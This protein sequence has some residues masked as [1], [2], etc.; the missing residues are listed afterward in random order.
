MARFESGAACVGQPVSINQRRFVDGRAVWIMRLCA[1]A[2]REMQ[3]LDEG[4]DAQPIGVAFEDRRAPGG[5]EGLA[6]TA[7]LKSRSR[8]R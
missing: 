3:A 4:S 7:P 1:V 6:S 2:L 8:C 5:G